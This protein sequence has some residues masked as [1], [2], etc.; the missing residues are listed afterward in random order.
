MISKTFNI[1]LLSNHLLR[2]FLLR[3]AIK[4]TAASNNEDMQLRKKDYLNTL[5]HRIDTFL[6]LCQW[7]T[8]WEKQRGV[9]KICFL[10]ELLF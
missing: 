4:K 5:A 7:V 6:T 10:S 2:E 1:L 3:K 9:G 8:F